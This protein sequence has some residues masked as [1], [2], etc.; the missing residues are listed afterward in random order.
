MIGAGAINGYG[1]N[2]AVG[3]APVEPPRAQ[4]IVATRY[5]LTLT[6][7][8]GPVEIQISSWQMRR[9]D[10][11]A[12]WL[13][14]IAPGATPALI[15][16]VASRLDGNL[17][18]VCETEMLTGE[19]LSDTVL[20]VAFTDFSYDR[21]ST[22]ASMTLT[23]NVTR[24]N[25]NPQTRLVYGETYRAQSGGTRRA[26]FAR[27]DPLLQPG[28]TVMFS[29]G[30]SWVVGSMTTWVGPRESNMEIGEAETD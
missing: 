23:S 12:V 14:I 3:S 5:R 25:I 21:G 26:R 19:I 7:G 28:D 2:A 15:A 17:V 24:R 8:A 11:G 27:H 29:D 4:S 18:L 30:E 10:D 9:R 6:G 13:S 22:S 20:D 16:A 1:L